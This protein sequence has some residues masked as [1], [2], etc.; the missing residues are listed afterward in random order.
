MNKRPVSYLQTDARWKT[1]PYAVTGESSTIGGAGCGPTSAAMLISTLTGK[2]FTPPDACAWALEHGYKALNQGTYHSYFVPQL[3]EYGITCK[4]LNT[5]S[6][7]GLPSS[8]VHARAMAL[9]KEGWYLIALMGKGLWTSSGHYI[10]VW[11]EDGKVR[12]NDPAST[13][14]SRLNGD[15]S[16]F[17][18]QC[19]YYWAI[20]ARSYNQEDDDMITYDQWKEYQEK[21]E[22]EKAEAAPSDWSQEART[23]AEGNSLIAGD[24]SGNM[25]YKSACTREQMVVF[26][27]RLYEKLAGK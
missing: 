26:L 11:W 18:A 9:I 21:Y 1:V 12:I 15:P 17:A 19:K 4:R 8:P 22:A 6:I 2:T 5:S 13:R 7:Y 3:S 24:G 20:D 27:K 25:Q 10:V 16:T 14:E 23:W